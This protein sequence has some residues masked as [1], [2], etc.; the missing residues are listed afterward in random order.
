MLARWIGGAFCWLVVSGWWLVAVVPKKYL[1]IHT[2]HKHRK[3]SLSIFYTVNGVY[4]FWK[5][6][7]VIYS[8]KNLKNPWLQ[9]LLIFEY[10]NSPYYGGTKM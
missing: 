6:R 5:K 9:Q 1:H 7:R 3:K 8:K 10:P 4:S 2:E